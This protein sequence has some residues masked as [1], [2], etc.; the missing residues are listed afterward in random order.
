ML[1]ITL[2]G[3]WCDIIVLH[4]HAQTDDKSHDTKDNFY[5][6]LEHVFDQFLKYQIKILLDFS[7]MVGRE[8]IFKTKIRNE[9][10]HEISNHNGV[11]GVNAATSENLFVESTMFS[12]ITFIT[13]SDFS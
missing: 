5:V 9:S 4:E 6:E 11:T 1:Y 2:R 13:Y 7:P 3:H 10:V 12:L 8:D